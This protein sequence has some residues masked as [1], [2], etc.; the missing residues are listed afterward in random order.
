M[1]AQGVKVADYEQLIRSRL[2]EWLAQRLEASQVELVGLQRL[3]G[4][5]SS[6]TWKIAY[7]YQ[8]RNASADAE[9]VLR[10]GP[11][12]GL[13]APYDI[14]GQYRLLKALEPTPVPAPAPLWL[15]TDRTILGEPFLTMKVVPGTTGP[16]F[17]PLADPER[18]EKLRAYVRTLV[19]IHDLDW[20]HFGIDE[21]LS[22]PSSDDC[23]KIALDGILALVEQRG[24]S[25]DRRAKRAMDWLS[26]RVPAHSEIR[27]IHGDPNLSNYR[28]E[29]RSVVAVIDWEMAKLSDPLWDVGFY[30]GAI[31]K[32]Y[33]D[34]S[35]L[36]RDRE[37]ATF[38]DLYHEAT[39]RSFASLEYWEVLFTLRAA[40][41]SQLPEMR[42]NRTPTYWEQL[43]LL[44]A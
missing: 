2:P 4:G 38:L 9:C 11:E 27:L 17:F 13:G 25:E 22:Q 28:F 8:K 32:F 3:A 19:T 24:C 37:R 20:R 43:A 6:E 42:E 12:G 30:C 41:G 31:A 18:D 36:V 10:W 23:A 34:Q 15:E 5:F 21:I 33:A 1:S 40:S 44:T 7:A 16:R 29:G 14:P 35:Q 39:G 26:E